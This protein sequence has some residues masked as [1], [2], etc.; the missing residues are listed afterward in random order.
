MSD[1]KRHFVSYSYLM[2]TQNKV[3]FQSYNYAM[4]LSVK[5]EIEENSLVVYSILNKVMII[6]IVKFH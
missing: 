6:R 1:Y 2:Y 5:L 3:V 4:W